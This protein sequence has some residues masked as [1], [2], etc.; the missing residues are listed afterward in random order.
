MTFTY[1]LLSSHTATK[2][3]EW[4]QTCLNCVS[5]MNPFSYRGKKKG[6]KEVM[7]WQ[8]SKI[9]P[10]D[11][12]WKLDSRKPYKSTTWQRKESSKLYKIR[13]CSSFYPP[14]HTSTEI[15]LIL[16]TS[17]LRSIPM[18]A[19]GVNALTQQLFNTSFLPILFY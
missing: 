14:L 7:N 1:F 3:L 16:N 10:P 19:S 8:C 13:C 2:W 15:V 6:Y 9:I 11:T 12:V 5:K 4:P 17:F 18:F